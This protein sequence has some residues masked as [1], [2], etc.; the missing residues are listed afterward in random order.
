MV[1]LGQRNEDRKIRPDD[2]SR[3]EGASSKSHGHRRAMLLAALAALTLVGCTDLKYAECIAR[4]RTSNP[5][6]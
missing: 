2:A 3:H 4:D 6:N 1:P 5:C